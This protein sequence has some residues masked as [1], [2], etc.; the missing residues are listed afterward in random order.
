MVSTMQQLEHKQCASHA[1][2]S[3]LTVAVAAVLC[4][5][6]CSAV[7]LLQTLKCSE[8]TVSLWVARWR[9]ERSVADAERSGRPRCTSDDTDQNIMLHS[10]AHVSDNPKDIVRALELD[11]SARTVRRR[12]NEIDL[13]SYVQ[14][15]EHENIRAR[16]SFAEGYSRW[17][18]DDWSRVMFS[19]EVHFPLGHQGREYV[20]RPPGAGL[21][22]KYTRK[23]NERLEGKVS[24]WQSS[25][26]IPWTRVATKLFSV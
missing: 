18:E 5:V 2:C 1:V 6:K 23:E 22:P 19:D 21:D 25:T 16:L 12:L 20:Q 13:H 9:D 3:A 8:N 17:T 4:A 14:R 7:D 11:V 15:A 10:D 26:S 24:L